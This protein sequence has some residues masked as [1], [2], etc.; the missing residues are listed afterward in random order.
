MWK[1]LS[2]KHSTE[3]ITYKQTMLQTIVTENTFFETVLALFFYRRRQGF[4]FIGTPVHGQSYITNFLCTSLSAEHNFLCNKI[5][6]YHMCSVDGS[7]KSTSF[8]F[9]KQFSESILSLNPYI[10]Q[11]IHFD[12]NIQPFFRKKI[13]LDDVIVCS[14]HLL[15]EPL[16]KV[17][18]E[19]PR[20]K[21]IIIIEFPDKCLISGKAMNIINILRTLILDL[22]E[23]FKILFISRQTIYDFD[24]LDFT[25]ID[26]IDLTRIGRNAKRFCIQG[27]F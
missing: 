1:I 20:R 10:G 18:K 22:P 9:I 14:G 11:Q 7:S 25:P 16:R 4:H 13:C 15:L 3:R 24:D 8:L 6:F 21:Y 26:S 17:S 2:D 27:M 5:I 19:Q 12:L 23:Q